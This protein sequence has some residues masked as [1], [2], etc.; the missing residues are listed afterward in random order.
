MAQDQIRRNGGIADGSIVIAL[1][2]LEYAGWQEIKYN[3]AVEV[4]PIWGL[5]N[6]IRGPRGVTPGVYKPGEGELKGPMSTCDTFGDVLKATAPLQGGKRRIS[7]V[8]FIITV[9]FFD[10]TAKL[11]VL[12]GCRVIGWDDGIPAADSADPV[13]GTIKLYVGDITRNGRHL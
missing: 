1:N 8:E 11:H 3:D 6:K 13:T 9:M 5:S 4:K 12:S 2:G 10:P 7:L